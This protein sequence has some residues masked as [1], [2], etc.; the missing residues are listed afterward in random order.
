MDDINLMNKQEMESL[1]TYGYMAHRGLLISYI[2]TGHIT[3]I[4]PI[5]ELQNMPDRTFVKMH[6]IMN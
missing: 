1:A 5:P 4:N 6:I 3:G 2:I